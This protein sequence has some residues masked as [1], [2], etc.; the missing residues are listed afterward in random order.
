MVLNGNIYNVFSFIINKLMQIII[1]PLVT[2]TTRDG[3]KTKN[4][5][6]RWTEVGQTT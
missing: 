2:S 3:G 5:G 6:E 4:T 1:L